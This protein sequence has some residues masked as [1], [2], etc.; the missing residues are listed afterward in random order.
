[1]LQTVAPKVIPKEFLT[2]VERIK[3]QKDQNQGLV[4]ET[5]T[6]ALKES[7]SIGRSWE[8]HWMVQTTVERLKVLLGQDWD[9]RTEALTE[10]LSMGRS[11]E[12]H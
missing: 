2:K 6:E 12:H 9:P 7:L 5:R 4:K 8:H 11:W 1:M 10:P 3:V